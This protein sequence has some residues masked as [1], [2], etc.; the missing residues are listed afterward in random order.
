MSLKPCGECTGY[1]PVER[2]TKGG[3]RRALSYG[4][5][6]KK[7]IFA[8]NK[9]G[10]PVYPPKAIVAELPNAVHDLKI[11]KSNHLEKHCNEFSPRS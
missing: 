2:G 10:N 11:V 6:L 7:S 3:A 1:H 4:Y 8:S 5:C 9:P